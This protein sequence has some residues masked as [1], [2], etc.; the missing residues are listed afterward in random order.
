MR[1]LLMGALLLPSLAAAQVDPRCEGL[2]KPL[3][4]DEQTQQDYLANYVALATTWS[5]G[6]APIPHE[7]GHG[8]IG[9]SVAVIPP[10][11]CSRR[12]VLNW[13]KTEDTNKAPAAPRPFVRFALPE[14]GAFT[15]YASVGYL[16]PI[17]LLGTRNV[18]LS[19]AFGVGAHL[20]E[21][22]QVGGRFHATTQKTIGEIATPFVDGDPEVLDL[23]LASTFGFDLM[24]GYELGKVTPY[25]SVGFTDVSTFF[26]IGD[27]SV[28]TSNLHPYA[29]LATSLGAEGRV[30]ESFLWSAEFYAAPG[31][32]SKPETDIESLPGFGRYGSL[33]TGRLQLAV[34]L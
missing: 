19:G 8:A 14:V 15:P 2:E 9:L 21:K 16:P 28:V 18:I 10:L 34:E 22:G 13:N 3:D 20:G 12:Y 1:G 24:A 5:A 23:Y 30:G 31:G 11:S 17:P 6:H 29:G 33:Y 32:H 27:D 26:Y 4:Y 7:A 25:L